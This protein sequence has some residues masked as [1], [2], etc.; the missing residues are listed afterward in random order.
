MKILNYLAYIF[1]FGFSFSP[2]SIANDK[3][4]SGTIVVV[5]KNDDT[6]DFI[7]LQS[8]KIKFTRKTGK[9]PHEL[10][11]SANGHTAVVTNYIGGNSLTIFDVQQ[12]RKIKTIDLSSYP[13]PHGIMFLKDQQRVAV[14]SEDSN[15]VVIVNITS[16]KIEKVI[17]TQQEGSHMVALPES[18]EYI[19]T[20]NM[21]SHTVSELDV[22]SGTLLRK[23]ST[24]NVPEA[25]TI[26]KSGTELWVGSNKDGLVSVFNLANGGLI[27]QW[28]GFSFPYRILL[29]RDEQFAVIPDY[30]NDTLDIIDVKNKKKLHQIDFRWRTI[31]KGVIYHPDDR[32]LFMSSYGKDK[33]IVID[34]PSGEVLFELPTG[35]GPDGI[36][37]SPLVLQ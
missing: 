12:A 27:K 13:R 2:N 22:Q 5:N 34:I 3:S 36:G 35:D 9:G 1:I 19:Y 37:Y 10:A 14:S 28:Q 31:P 29:T 7:D 23:I 11:M 16:G 21:G 18:S 15:N 30:K 4:L 33:I 6:V 25:I 32:T 24:P 8:R 26:N 17:G 20:T